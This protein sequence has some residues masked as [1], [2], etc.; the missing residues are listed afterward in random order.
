MLKYN[1]ATG[2]LDD[3]A[4]I[5]AAARREVF[6]R[7][8]RM[9]LVDRIHILTAS[10]EDQCSSSIFSA[11]RGSCATVTPAA[12]Q[13]ATQGRSLRRPGRGASRRQGWRSGRR[14]GRRTKRWRS[15]VLSPARRATRA[16]PGEGW[17]DNAAVVES[18][19]NLEKLLGA[20]R[21]GRTVVLPGDKATPKRDGRLP[22]QDRRARIS[23]RLRYQAAA[24]H[25]DTFAKK[26]RRPSRNSVSPRRPA[27]SW[28]NGTT[29]SRRRP[30]PPTCSRATPT[31]TAP[32]GRMGRRFREE[33]GYGGPG[34]EG[35]RGRRAGHAGQ[36]RAGDR[37]QRRCYRSSSKPGSSSPA[38]R[39]NVGSDGSNGATFTLTKE[40]A[41]SRIEELKKGYRVSVSSELA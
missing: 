6:D 1:P 2:M 25:A 4:T 23:R 34:R 13:A 35:A 14:R 40:A 10:E 5:A 37:H 27:R 12:R 16:D 26:P 18:Y 7:L 17:K 3:K 20:D 19:A 32:A 41:N 36:D 15:V 33:H 38:R 28:R 9:L 29:A 39:A 24:G 21:A 8:E 22:R 31:F 30:T 11:R